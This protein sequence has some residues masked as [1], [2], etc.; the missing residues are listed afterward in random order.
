MAENNQNS[1]AQ[2]YAAKMIDVVQGVFRQ[3]SSIEFSQDPVIVD[4]NLI[5]YDSRMRVFGLEKF[6]GPSYASSVSFYRSQQ[7]M[8]SHDACG[9]MNLFIEEEAAGKLLKSLGY[10]GFDDSDDDAVL[11]HCADFCNTI[12]GNF[13]AELSKMGFSNLSMSD[14]LKEKNNIAAGVDFPYSQYIYHEVQFFIWKQ[15][16]VAVDIVMVPTVK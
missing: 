3:K 8:Q 15:K 13:N 7:Q 10:T 4:K 14:P 16:A 2:K 6:N 5:E 9:V 12:A 1:D 11:E